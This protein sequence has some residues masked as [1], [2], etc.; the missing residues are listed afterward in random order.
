MC[1]EKERG[2]TRGCLVATLDRIA[3]QDGDYLSQNFLVASFRKTPSDSK[4]NISRFHQ[5]FIRLAEFAGKLDRLCRS[6]EPFFG[7]LGTAEQEAQ[8]TIEKE[9]TENIFVNLGNPG[10]I[11][12]NRLETWLG[13]LVTKFSGLSLLASAIRRDCAVAEMYVTQT[14]NVLRGWNEKAFEGY[15]TNASAEMSQCEAKIKR[16][17]NF[18]DRADALRTQL[19]TVLGLIQTYLSFAQQKTAERQGNI[20]KLLTWVMAIF[21][22]ILVLIEI[23]AALHILR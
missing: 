5:E 18:L 13:E 3:A 6:N 21:T 4:P 17:R 22:I 20:L 19:E 23:L 14:E 9:T 10:Q 12:I 8:E 16:F 1:E 2:I 15:P 7:T 11:Q